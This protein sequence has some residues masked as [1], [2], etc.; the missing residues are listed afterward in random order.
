MHFHVLG[1]GSI[2]TLLAHHIRRTVDP[3]HAVVLMH[4]DK[5]RLLEATRKG[6]AISVQSRGVQET[7]T[8]YEHDLVDAYHQPIDNTANVTYQAQQKFREKQRRVVDNTPIQSL[9]VTLK[10][11][12]ILPALRLLLPRIRPSTTIVLMHNGLGVYERLIDELFRNSVNRPHFILTSNTHGAYTIENR[13]LSVVHASTKGSALKFGV[14]P[15][16]RGRPLEQGIL[17]GEQALSL[18]ALS[19]SDDPDAAHYASLRNTVTVLSNLVGL[20]SSW[21]PLSDLLVEMKRK[22]VVNSVI[23]PLTAIM[24]CRNGDVATSPHTARICRAICEE[25]S[26]AFAL[27]YNEQCIT[28]ERPPLH[29]IPPLTPNARDAVLSRLPTT[30]RADALMKQVY[31]VATDT[32]FN[33]SSMLQDIRTNRKTEVDYMN[34]YLV[35][36]GRRYKLQMRATSMLANMVHLRQ[37]IPLDLLM[38]LPRPEVIKE[39][40]GTPQDER[41]MHRAWTLVKMRKFKRTRYRSESVHTRRVLHAKRRRAGK[42]ARAHS[43]TPINAPNTSGID[44]GKKWQY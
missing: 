41:V 30:L 21:I 29:L 12:A 4:K 24:N 22:V 37:E 13:L 1:L 16:P 5:S 44:D 17:P 14:A 7:S 42:V 15:D 39:Q 38:D 3:K 43:E 26:L 2:G 35:S 32:R 10:A 8:G 34:G 40:F 33:T 18:D 20:N 19:T 28:G 31:R 23:N 6:G 25:A 36:L 9:F 27:Q 11:Y